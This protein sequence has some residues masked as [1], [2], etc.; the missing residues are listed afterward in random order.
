MRCAT[1]VAALGLLA[2]PAAA[3][4]IYTTLE[5]PAGHS[6]CGG[7]QLTGDCEPISHP[8][9]NPDGSATFFSRR[10]HA[11]VLVAHGILQWLPVAGGEQWEAHWCGVPRE[12]V[13]G[14]RDRPGGD[15][16]D[17]AYWTYCAF[18]NPGGV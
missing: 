9:L 4:D 3:H 10:Y 7:D 11:P 1:A 16:I 5:S 18:W 13:A 8:T 6:C 17:A 12:R 15:Q 14:G 2:G